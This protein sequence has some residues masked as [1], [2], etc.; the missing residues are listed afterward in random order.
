MAIFVS[1]VSVELRE[2]VLREKP[3]DMLD[4]SP[5]G[6][7]P[8]LLL[9][10]GSVLEESRDIML[11][12]LDQNDPEGWL[13]NGDSGDERS[14]ALVEAC[15]G[16]F[17]HHLDR[18]KYASRYEGA[19]SQEHRIEAEAFLRVLENQMA[20]VFFIDGEKPG[21]SDYAIMPF[22]RQFANTDREWFDQAP[23][24]N[25]QSRLQNFLTS[26]VFLGVMQKYPQWRQGDEP[27][28]FPA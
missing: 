9:P 14:F 7:V 22:I 3:Q 2:V 1:G 27:I 28:V 17:K 21:F 16:N 6:T 5:K 13:L 23:Y 4:V 20:E 18:Y 11:W 26:D 24:P 8:V 15:D 12:A 10:D 19:D 25:L